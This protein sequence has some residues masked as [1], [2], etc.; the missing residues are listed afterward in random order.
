MEPQ[1]PLRLASGGS[2]AM[3]PCTCTG[4]CL[5]ALLFHRSSV[6]HSAAPCWLP[7]RRLQTSQVQLWVVKHHGGELRPFAV[8]AAMVG[9][10]ALPSENSERAMAM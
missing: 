4:T 3:G 5:A 10:D 6:P 7:P 1:A 8:R 9:G 2:A